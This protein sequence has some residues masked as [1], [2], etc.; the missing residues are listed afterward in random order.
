MTVV[1]MVAMKVEMKVDEWAYMM[2]EKKVVAK[3]VVK[4]D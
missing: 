2:A 4:V 1:R 3:V